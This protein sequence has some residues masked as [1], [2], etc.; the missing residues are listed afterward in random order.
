MLV[1]ADRTRSARGDVPVGTV[2]LGITPDSNWRLSVDGQ[3]VDVRPAFGVTSAYDIPTAGDAVLDYRTG[4]GRRAALLVVGLAWLATVLA[5]SRLGVPAVL[6]RSRTRDETLLDLDREPGAVDLAEL[7]RPP[8]DRTGFA[9]WVDELDPPDAATDALDADPLAPGEWA[10]L[11]PLVPID[12]GESAVSAE[13][14]AADD[15]DEDDIWTVGRDRA[16]DGGDDDE[17]AG[18]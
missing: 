12:F 2:H 13:R 15:V 14:A 6:R 8:G 16:A 3:D 9:G 10:P 18:R 11:S 7:D 5:A 1:G 17:E 4:G